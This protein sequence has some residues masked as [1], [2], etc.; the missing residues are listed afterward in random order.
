MKVKLQLLAGEGFKHAAFCV[1]LLLGSVHC[2]GGDVQLC[3]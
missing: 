2:A 1:T 3:L